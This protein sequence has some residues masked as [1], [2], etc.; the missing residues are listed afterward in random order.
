M[1][2]LLA[3]GTAAAQGWDQYLYLRTPNAAITARVTGDS[4]SSPDLQLS[5]DGKTL[6][7]RAFGQTVF[8][9]LNGKELGGTVGREL[10]RLSFE[11]H[12]GVTHARGS[13]YGRVSELNISAEELTGTVGACSYDL[14]ATKDGSYVGSRSCGGVPERPVILDIPPALAK[15]GTAM[16]LA[17]LGLI[18]GVP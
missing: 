3:M 18:L 15:Q 14:K 2:A 13:F 9:G 5:R 17:T 6:R 8:L 1:T 7:G 12:D 4:I 11:D 16:T 10:T